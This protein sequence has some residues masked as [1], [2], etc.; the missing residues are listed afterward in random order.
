MSFLKKIENKKIKIGICISVFAALLV[1]GYFLTKSKIDEKNLALESESYIETYTIADSEKI[2]VN[3]TILPTESKDF[4]LPG[5]GDISTLKVQNGQSVKKGDL[6]FTVKNDLILSEID[7]LKSQINVLKNENIENDPSLNIE[8]SKLEEQ[9]SSLNKKAYTNTYA[10]FNGKI[11][12]NESS[13]E[14]PIS[15]FMTLI[16]N[17]FYMKGQVSE[18]NLPKLN[19]DDPAKV[20]IFSNEKN[21]NGRISFISDRPSTG[22][23]NMDMNMGGQGNLSYYDIKISFDSQDGLVNGFHSQA[24][25]EIVDTLVKVPTSA[26]LEDENGSYVFKDYNGVLKKQVVEIE[27]KNDDFT[28][29]KSGLDKLEVIIRYPSPEM[30]EGDPVNTENSTSSDGNDSTKPEDSEDT[31]T[32]EGEN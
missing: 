24:T 16:S 28:V 19:I 23:N 27:S 18:Q 25:I 22:T 26:I 15:S 13:E 30:L 5:E 21:L 12:L 8:I 11:Y 14:Q 31:S 7:S 6:L 29:V 17:E 2:F 32:K 1:G 3:G 10:T 20:L 9:V 4:N